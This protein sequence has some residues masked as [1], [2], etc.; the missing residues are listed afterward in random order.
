[1]ITSKQRKF[2]K[3]MA[4]SIDPILQIGKGGL[5]ES[6]LKQID[7]SLESRELIKVNVLNN[8][9]LDANELANE[10]SETLRAEYV[11]SIGNKF[12]IYRESQEKKKIELPRK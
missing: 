12:V 3:S 10:I 9:Q 6:V 2:L 8:S 11:Q 5:T 1:M 4:H 7:Q